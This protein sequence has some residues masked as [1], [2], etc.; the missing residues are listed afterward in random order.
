MSYTTTNERKL[1][2]LQRAISEGDARR[3]R[4]F[5]TE[6]GMYWG[7]QGSLTA[8]PEEAE[9]YTRD[10]LRADL[11]P[12]FDK[13]PSLHDVLKIYDLDGQELTHY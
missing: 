13:D 5:D 6:K 12:D 3:Y 9:Q 2:F 1:G 11:A 10:E 4:I 7:D 8:A